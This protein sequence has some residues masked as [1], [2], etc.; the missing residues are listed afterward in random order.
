MLFL[1]WAIFFFFWGGGVF[2]LYFLFLFCFKCQPW[3]PR[4]K[5]LVVIS[6]HKRAGNGSA[7]RSTVTLWSRTEKHSINSYTCPQAR[8]WVNEWA[9]KWAQ[10]SARDKWAEWSKPMSERRDRTS[11][12]IWASGLVLFGILGCSGPKWTRSTNR[13]EGRNNDEDLGHINNPN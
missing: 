2:D 6:D 5:A 9:N 13:S 3:T 12:R 11:K 1:V 10:R 4:R 7:T 8:E